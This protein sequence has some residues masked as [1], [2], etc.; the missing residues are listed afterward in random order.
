M[1]LWAADKEGQMM[2]MLINDPLMLAVTT[3]FI[4]WLGCCIG[5]FL[6]VCIWRIPRGESIVHP[7]SHCPVC[8]DAIPF[9]LNVP[10]LSWCM[11]RGKCRSC[12]TPISPRYVI[13]ELLVGLLY[14]LIWGVVLY[15]KLPLS[16][17][18]GWLTLAPILVTCSFIDIEKHIIPNK[19]TY[20]GVAAGLI[21]SGFFPLM[22][23]VGQPG[24]LFPL[25]NE[26]FLPLVKR[27]LGATSPLGGSEQ[28]ESLILSFAGFA[29]GYLFLM[30]FIECGKLLMGKELVKVKDAVEFT[31][32]GETLGL[33]GEAH[34]L[35]A[36]IMRKSDKVV[37]TLENA[38]VVS[39]GYDELSLNGK[40][41]SVLPDGM[42]A[43]KWVLPREVMGYGD[44]KLL[45]AC[46]AFLGM[47]GAIL[48]LMIAS[49]AG[50]L[51]ML[52]SAVLSKKK[53]RYFPFGGFLALGV[54]LLLVAFSG[55]V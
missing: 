16:V 8:N 21:F 33:G 51:L 55:L 17:L 28:V 14:L 47:E 1:R 54:L 15:K 18:P 43:V 29:F 5:S 39:I 23:G 27:V 52:P 22:Q 46:G 13:V 9:Y 53:R 20:F 35:S 48:T 41:V 25:Q 2:E 3:L 36:F 30:L 45:A 31:F 4:F 37:V 24:V 10:I 38:D 7:P 40:S 32:D 34:L 12:K 11:L 50:T 44:A 42:K 26:F 6:N 19:L 49:V